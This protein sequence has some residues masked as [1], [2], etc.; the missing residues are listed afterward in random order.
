MTRPQ[1]TGIQFRASGELRSIFQWNPRDSYR[2]FRSIQRYAQHRR[3]ERTGFWDEP[4]SG[5]IFELRGA[6][7]E[8]GGIDGPCLYRFTT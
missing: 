8:P 1:W 6:A 2:M 4:E 5:D 3:G 7:N